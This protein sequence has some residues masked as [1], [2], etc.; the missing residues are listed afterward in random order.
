MKWI[1]LFLILFFLYGMLEAATGTFNY[2]TGCVD[3][4]Q[5]GS[6][7]TLP[8]G[9]TNY[10]QNTSSPTILTQK[11]NVQ[12]GKYSNLGFVMNDGTNRWGLTVSTNGALTSIV[13]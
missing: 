11:F 1:L 6:T 4:T 3:F 13:K 8:P 2:C 5:Q 9:S 10:I 7:S 12:Q